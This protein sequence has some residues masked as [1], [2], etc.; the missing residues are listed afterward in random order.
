MSHCVL[1]I[2]GDKTYT[3]NL[4]KDPD[5]SENNLLLRCHFST[6]LGCSCEGG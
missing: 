4:E 1:F 6:L 3:I 2:K 5:V